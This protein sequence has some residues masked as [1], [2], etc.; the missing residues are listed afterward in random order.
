MALFKVGDV[1]CHKS[2]LK[3]K[4]VV[5]RV[6]ISSRGCSLFGD[7]RTQIGYHLEHINYKG[8]RSYDYFVEPLLTRAIDIK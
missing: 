6:D 4:F 8:E 3:V 7:K 2:N 1:V 5:S